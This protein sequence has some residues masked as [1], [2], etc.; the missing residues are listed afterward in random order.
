MRRQRDQIAQAETLLCKI[1][2]RVLKCHSLL[3]Y[4]IKFQTWLYENGFSIRKS[5]MDAGVVEQAEGALVVQCSSV[6]PTVA[7][8]HKSTSTIQYIIHLD[9]YSTRKIPVAR[10]PRQVWLQA[11]S[12][13]VL[14]GRKCVLE[15]N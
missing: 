15:G 6:Q 14:V 3:L 4:E 10:R 7:V 8:I 12:G 5:F 13:C 2:C 1:L 11:R 9:P